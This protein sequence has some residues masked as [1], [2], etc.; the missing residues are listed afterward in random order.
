MVRAALRFSQIDM[1]RRVAL[2]DHMEL[3]VVK[4]ATVW[5]VGPISLKGLVD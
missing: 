1:I 3:E 5:V 4:S 2:K